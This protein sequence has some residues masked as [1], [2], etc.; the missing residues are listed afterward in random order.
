MTQSLTL[1]IVSPTRGNFSDYWLEQLL[2]IKG[3][4]EFNLVYPPDVTPVN[5]ADSRVKII[6]SPYK[7]EVIQ[8]LIGLLNAQ[9][10]YVLALDDD[11][12]A[13][14]DL[15]LLVESYFNRF[16]ESWVLRL[17]K[18]GIDGK[19]EEKIKSPWQK[20][21][22]INQLDV[23]TRQG[24]KTHGFES[25]EEKLLELPIVPLETK[26]DRQ[27]LISPY[28]KRKDMNGI[29]IENFNNKVWRN[30]LV[31]ESLRDL[32]ET[33]HLF[34]HLKWIPKWNLDRLLGLF[35]QA[36]FYVKDKIVGHWILGSEQIRYILVNQALKGD[37]RL[38]LPSDGLLVKRFPQYG[39]FWNLSFEQFWIAVKKLGRRALSNKVTTLKKTVDL[40]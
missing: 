10:K 3:N 4:I 2:N 9:G 38:M 37:F 20:I 21:P 40:K 7:G 31:N 28:H 12:F 1:S 15:Y 13:H 11:D 34:G 32:S 8:R 18:V 5:I 35:L 30:D 26:F 17:G 33:T 24:R 22:D 27:F 14:P 19:E 16:P 6:V 29:H 25:E 23:W 39:Y 36:K